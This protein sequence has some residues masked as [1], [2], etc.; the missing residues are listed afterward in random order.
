MNPCKSVALL[1]MLS[2]VCAGA[3]GISSADSATASEA[4]KN[5]GIAYLKSGNLPLA[6]EKLERARDQSPRSGP[7]RGA[8]A[9]LYARLG[10]DGKAD[11]E[12]N[13]ALKYSKN[14]PDQQNNYAVFL[15][16]RGRH[17]EGVKIFE[18]AA[19]NPLYRTPWSAYTN[20]GVCLR[21]A[22][23][24]DEAAARFTKAL[25]LRPNYAEA[26]F[27]AG[28]LELSQHHAADV[29]KRIDTYLATYPATADLLFLG[30]R[31][32]R[33]QGDQVAAFRMA[34]RLQADFSGSEQARAASAA[35]PG[36]STAN[37][38]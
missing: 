22:Q 5:L 15:C 26:V 17:A 16:S 8:L 12:F 37:E 1:A 20:A 30:W 35:T 10:E 31:A 25:A 27:Q 29:Y 2:L 11:A 24:A 33:E 23:Q 9:L 19:S 4:N 13:N 14:D 3:Q 38:R 6:K 28:D 7:V 32:A 34:R 21:N 18:Q 36:T